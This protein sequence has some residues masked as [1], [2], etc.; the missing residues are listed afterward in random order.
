MLLLWLTLSGVGVYGGIMVLETNEHVSSQWCKLVLKINV[1]SQLCYTLY[2]L[3]SAPIELCYILLAFSLFTMTNQEM[4]LLLL[5]LTLS[6]V[7]DY[8]GIMILATN[9]QLSSQWCKAGNEINC[10]IKYPRQ[11]LLQSFQVSLIC[12]TT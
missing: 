7:G 9:E 8:V 3:Y 5:W 2:Y 4:L 12:L 6:G 1:T 10:M 11:R